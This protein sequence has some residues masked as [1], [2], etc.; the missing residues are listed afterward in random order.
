MRAV[1]KRY[2]REFVPA[3]AGCAVLIVMSGFLAPGTGSLPVRIVLTLLA[4]CAAVR[5]LRDQDEPE[6]RIDLES[7][8]I[9]AMV[10]GFGFFSFGLL[11]LADA[12]WQLRGG[13]VAIR[14]LP[15]LFASFGIAKLLV[16]R[17]HRNHA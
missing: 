15:C 12:G 10:T 6:R 16:S 4:I 2:L 7:F 11:Q 3:I 8:A 14:V 17:R 5:V 13:A 9:A 1:R